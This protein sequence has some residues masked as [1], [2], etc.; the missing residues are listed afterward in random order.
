MVTFN[1]DDDDDDDAQNI[2]TMNEKGDVYIK[3]TT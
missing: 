2:K 3:T 1:D